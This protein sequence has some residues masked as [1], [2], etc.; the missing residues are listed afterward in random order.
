[1]PVSSLDTFLSEVDRTAADIE[2]AAKARDTRAALGFSAK[3]IPQALV[4]VTTTFICECGARYEVPSPTTL[5]RYDHHGFNNSV[6]YRR[7]EMAAF[8]VLPR[9]RKQ[10]EVAVAF[11]QRCF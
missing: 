6:H 1:M 3:A 2:R 7:R 9:E 4:L 5:V 11:C 8:L 10:H